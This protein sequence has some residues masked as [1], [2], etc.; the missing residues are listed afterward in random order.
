MKPEGL[1]RCNI[2]PHSGGG[3]G[4]RVGVFT[5]WQPECANVA[6]SDPSDASSVAEPRS[7]RRWPGLSFSAHAI[8]PNF[9]HASHLRQLA[10]SSAFAASSVGAWPAGWTPGGAARAPLR[11]QTH[12]MFRH[13][14]LFT[15]A[16][17][18]PLAA[19]DSVVLPVPIDRRSDATRAH[20]EGHNPLQHYRPL[21]ESHGNP[22]VRLRGRRRGSVA[23]LRDGGLVGGSRAYPAFVRCPKRHFLDWPK[24]EAPA[25]GGDGR[26][27][28]LGAIVHPYC[29]RT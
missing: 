16:A 4:L 29:L 24:E 22:A 6:A 12:R 17:H 8:S 9:A 18:R 28:Q 20:R 10:L 3:N 7:C 1:V 15:D 13:A 23:P 19:V 2:P 21:C 14:P 5:V 27:F 25:D 26:G 11:D